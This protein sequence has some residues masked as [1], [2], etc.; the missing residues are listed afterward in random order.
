MGKI[1]VFPTSSPS[2]P[3]RSSLISFGRYV[4]RIRKNSPLDYLCVHVQPLVKKLQSTL[5]S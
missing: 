4:F 2:A 3:T 5:L 1:I